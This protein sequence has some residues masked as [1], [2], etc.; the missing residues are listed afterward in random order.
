MQWQ[1]SNDDFDSTKL[2]CFNHR[3]IVEV[4]IWPNLVIL[5][6][7]VPF[8]LFLMTVPFPLFLSRASCLI[9]WNSFRII[10]SRTMIIVGALLWWVGSGKLILI[11]W[12]WLFTVRI[13]IMMV[14]RLVRI[15]IRTCIFI[16]AYGVNLIRVKGIRLLRMSGL[17]Q[18]V[19]LWCMSG[20]RQ[21]EWIGSSQTNVCSII[22]SIWW[23]CSMTI[24]SRTRW[25]NTSLIKL[26]WYPCWSRWHYSGGWWSSV[27]FCH[28]IKIGSSSCAP[29]FVNVPE[30]PLLDIVH[31]SS[32][33]SRKNRPW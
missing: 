26:T 21:M 30:F 17:W 9:F 25:S 7:V 2:F 20:L 5:I 29:E 16:T 24:E 8:P 1:N 13:R 23:M 12:I 14:W 22:T 33:L 15:I 31:G 11:L 28:G 18:M 3:C 4:V 10:W 27:I 19:G 32:G 6:C